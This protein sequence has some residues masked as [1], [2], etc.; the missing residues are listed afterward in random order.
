M[1]LGSVGTCECLRHT[2]KS[3]EKEAGEPKELCILGL[4][5]AYVLGWGEIKPV[6]MG[7]EKGEGQIIVTDDLAIH[8]FVA[9]GL[10]LG[11]QVR[12]FHLEIGT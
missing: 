1:A 2:G 9:E 7:V 4:E 3:R 10:N 8:R 6:L 5:G 12:Q 11:N